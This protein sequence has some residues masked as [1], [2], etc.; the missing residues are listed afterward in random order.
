MAEISW[1]YTEEKDMNMDIG[2]NVCGN[3]GSTGGISYFLFNESSNHFLFVNIGQVTPPFWRVFSK[4]SFR[5]KL[6]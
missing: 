2:M 4:N 3:Y 6:K 5:F 1:I